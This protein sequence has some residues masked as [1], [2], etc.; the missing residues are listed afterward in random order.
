MK[1]IVLAASRYEFAKEGTGEM[2]RGL[3]LFVVEPDLI[4]DD[5]ARR[6]TRPFEVSGEYGMWSSIPPLPAVCEIEYSR[7]AG[8][9]GK[10]ETYVRSITDGVPVD[11]SLLLQSKLK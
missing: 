6:G 1:A 5:G 11:L 2:I 9:R 7:R 3:K 4:D 10:A 8:V